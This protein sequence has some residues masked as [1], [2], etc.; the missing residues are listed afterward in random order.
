[1]VARTHRWAGSI[2]MISESRVEPAR[3]RCAQF[4]LTRKRTLLP[5]QF[6]RV[7]IH[8][9][10][11]PNAILIPQAAVISG[12]RG[13][14]IYVVDENGKAEPRPIETGEWR[15]DQFLVTAGLKP[16]ERVIT[17][18]MLKIQPG[19]PVKVVEAKPTPAPQTP[20]AK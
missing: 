6:V 1:M 17:S 9:A 10:S 4:F 19:A 3:F 2:L 13:K 20:P 18:G 5:G 11:R 16:G 8:G 12:Q 7:A 15:E 14:L